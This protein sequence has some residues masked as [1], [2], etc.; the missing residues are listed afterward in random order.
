[1]TPT[2]AATQFVM[3]VFIGGALGVVYG[4]LRPLRPRW[5][6]ISDLLFLAATTYGVLFMSFAVAKG[7]LRPEHLLG[8]FMGGV[9]WEAFPGRWL[10]P[11]FAMVWLPFWKI[12]ECFS[13][14]FK[15]FFKKIKKFLLFP[16]GKREKNR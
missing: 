15:N 12:M 8:M 9:L 6:T 10:R 1:M 4:F 16:L 5:V 3:S 11:V 2:S 7:D 14:L 13:R